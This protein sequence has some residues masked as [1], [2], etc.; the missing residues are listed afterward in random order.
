MY[1]CIYILL[2]QRGVVRITSLL[3]QQ[4]LNKKKHG[5]PHMECAGPFAQ[6]LKLR[7]MLTLRSSTISQPVV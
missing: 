2:Y 5:E 1:V 7:F 6:P 4:S 3:L